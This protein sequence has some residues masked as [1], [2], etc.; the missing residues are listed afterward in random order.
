MFAAAVRIV[1][2]AAHR[3]R[4]MKEEC[5]RVHGHNYR[6][7]ASVEAE[8]LEEGMV[9]DFTLLREKLAAAVKEWDHRLLN[10]TEDFRGE[11]PTTEAIARRLYEKISASLPPGRYRLREVKVWETDECWASF[12]A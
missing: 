11:P 12:R 5:D 1:F 9:V 3:H 8:S 7:E 4:G 10:E 2:S 6:A